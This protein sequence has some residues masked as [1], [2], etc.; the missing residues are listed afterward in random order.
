M[1]IFE[2]CN[3]AFK[4]SVFLLKNAGIPRHSRNGPVLEHAGPVTFSF[5]YPQQ[6]VL[7]H[8]ERRINP[9]L[10]FFEPLWILAG[11]NDVKFMTTLVKKFADYSD[12]GETFAAPY[13]HRMR[14]PIDQIAHAID[15]LR[16]DPDDR[17]VVLQ[18]RV[19]EDITYTGKD[20]ACN[21]CVALKIRD[22]A[23]NIHVFN[24]SNDAIWGG[25]AGG[26]NFPQ[27]TMLQEY[28]AERI[29]VKIGYYY[30]T[31]DS[32]HVYTNEQ[33]DKIKNSSFPDVEYPSSYSMFYG[34]KHKSTDFDWDLETFFNWFDAHGEPARGDY[35]T[36]FFNEVVIPMWLAF[37]HD[38]DSIHIGALDWKRSVDLWRAE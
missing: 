38:G 33:W 34:V 10:H 26:T 2:N 35:I 23:L 19:P 27:F 5:R 37:K 31:T 15:R 6:R 11:R 22:D 18:I 29:G 4:T 32:M 30:H 25:P 7:F 3:D 21:M 13:G 28:L 16:V 20:T 36:P 24:R 9:F 8:K 17:R 14:K 1:F 12:N